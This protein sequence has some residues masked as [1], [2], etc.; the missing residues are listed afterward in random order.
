MKLHSFFVACTHLLGG[1]AIVV[2]QLFIG[3]SIQGYHADV[4]NRLTDTTW[5]ISPLGVFTTGVLLTLS[6]LVSFSVRVSR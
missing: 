2:G 5:T 4:L 6:G 1:F 3:A